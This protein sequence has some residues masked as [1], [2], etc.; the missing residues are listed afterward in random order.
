MPIE[1]LIGVDR[2]GE[3]FDPTNGE[4]L[5]NPEVLAKARAFMSHRFPALKNAPIIENRVCPYENSPDGNFILDTHPEADNCWFLGGGSGHGYKHGPALGEMAA[6]IVSG[7][8]DLENLFRM[9]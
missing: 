1:A 9:R 6:E 7:K 5:A 4:R 8:R 2:R 3:L